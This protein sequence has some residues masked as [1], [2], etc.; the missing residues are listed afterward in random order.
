MVLYKVVYKGQTHICLSWVCGQLGTVNYDHISRMLSREQHENYDS[1]ETQIL[2][3]IA[4]LETGI[5]SSK[6][7]AL[8][9]RI[10]P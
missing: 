1:L 4:T 6:G 8:N 7:M 5:K 9:V 2:L 10:D 3:S